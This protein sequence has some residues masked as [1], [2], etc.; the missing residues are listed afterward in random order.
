M[1]LP[2]ED[3]PTDLS[4]LAAEPVTSANGPSVRASLGRVFAIV[5]VLM[6]ACGGRQDSASSVPAATVVRASA[7]MGMSLNDLGRPF[8]ASFGRLQGPDGA[9]LFP[10]AQ[11]IPV[12]PQNAMK[13]DVVLVR[14]TQTFQAHASVWG[15]EAR[16][17]A[18]NS[19]RF[20]SYRAMIVREVHEVDDTTAMRRAPKT[21]VYYPARIYYGHVY[22]A[23]F[24]GSESNFNA[25]VAASL[26]AFSGGIE[27]F[28]RQHDLKVNTS[29]RG[30]TPKDGKAIFARSEEEIR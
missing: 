21:A 30:L 19:Q 14:D 4:S 13:H 27:D 11:P 26:G 16:A 7:P 1:N 12:T 10:K 22:E 29:A 3:H 17:G 8:D 28:A 20:A 2:I 25:G 15:F 24:S 23:V 18:S 6:V 5:A 9:S